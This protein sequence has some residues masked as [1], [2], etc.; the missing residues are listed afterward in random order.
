MKPVTIKKIKDELHYKSTQELIEL[1]LKLSKF[2]KENKELLSYLLFDVEDE[3]TYIYNVNEYITLLFADINTKSFFYIRKSVRKILKLTKKYIRYSKKKETEVELLL[4]FC[5]EL[6]KLSPSISK[7]P[8]LLNVYNR[9]LILIKK[10]IATLHEDLQY[11][12][13]LEFDQLLYE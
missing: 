1:C 7:S 11:D 10:A 9:Q 2:K 4:H 6:K 5:K 3:V 8:R 13:Q 12:Y